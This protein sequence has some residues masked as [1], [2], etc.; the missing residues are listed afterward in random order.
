MDPCNVHV[1]SV[2]ARCR[3]LLEIVRADQ[4]LISPANAVCAAG[5]GTHEIGATRIGVDAED[6]AFERVAAIAIRDIRVG[7][8]LADLNRAIRV[9]FEREDDLCV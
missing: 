7:R 5:D 8:G 9:V 3:D 4:Y 6:R 2:P 1:E